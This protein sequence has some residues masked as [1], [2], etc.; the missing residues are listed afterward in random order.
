[1]TN[2]PYDPQMQKDEMLH[3]LL[4]GGQAQVLAAQTAHLSQYAADLH[5]ASDVCA[6]AMSRLLTATL[7]IGVSQKE[8]ASSVTV[9]LAGDGAGGKMVCVAHH[10]TAKISVY[11]PQ[12]QADSV[13]AFVG[14]HGRLSVVKDF[15]AGEPY[16]GQCALVS[17]EI[18][19]DFAQYFTISEQQ[20]SLVALGALC[21]QGRV[22]SSGGVLIRS[23]PGCEEQT[24]AAL[25]MRAML[26][27]S[28][29]RDLA[30][31]PIE[32]LCAQWFDGLDMQILSRTPLSCRCDCS[33]ERM[34]RALVATGRQALEEMIAQGTGAELTCHFCR[35]TQ[36]FA[37]DELVDLLQSAK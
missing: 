18:A 32:E 16:V 14:A 21:T 2:I 26:F 19:E 7:M 8:D 35:T 4:K 6:V 29:S 37:T 28:V 17:G 9:T 31:A 20:P 15:G 25:D 36:T 5:G 10:G 23:M 12:A 22:L 30:Q 34:A 3:I 13:K 33:R 11:N 1:M 27:S 24:L